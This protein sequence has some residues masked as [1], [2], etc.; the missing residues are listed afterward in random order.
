M[1]SYLQLVQPQMSDERQ[2]DSLG[3]SARLLD[4]SGWCLHTQQNKDGL[5]V[6]D[7]YSANVRLCMGKH[8]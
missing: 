5:S 2:S 1:S 7:G 6:R 8:V 3:H 4:G